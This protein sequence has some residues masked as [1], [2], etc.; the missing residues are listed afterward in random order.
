MMLPAISQEPVL[1]VRETVRFAVVIHF[2]RFAQQ[3]KSV[4]LVPITQTAISQGYVALIQ[5]LL[6]ERHVAVMECVGIGAL[7][8]RADV[9]SAAYFALEAQLTVGQVRLELAYKQL[10]VFVTQE[11][12]VPELLVP[13]MRV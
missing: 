6:R 1:A 7:F 2:V 11:P 10:P 4:I 12:V 9:L 8:L 5:H 3:V 13:A